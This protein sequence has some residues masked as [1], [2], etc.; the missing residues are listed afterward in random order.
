MGTDGATSSPGISQVPIPLTTGQSGK[1]SNIRLTDGA[2]S[3][4]K[5]LRSI[6]DGEG[7]ETDN[8]IHPKEIPWLSMI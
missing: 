3:Y 6:T 5:T 1:Q 8:T 7:S 2:T 4:W